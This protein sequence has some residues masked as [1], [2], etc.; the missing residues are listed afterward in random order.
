MGTNYYLL[1]DVCPHCNREASRKHIGKS[2]GG[3][4]FSLH[5]EP[6]DHEF[7]QSLE[8][9]I[10]LWSIPGNKIEDEY[11]QPVDPAEMLSIITERLWKNGPLMRHDYENLVRYGDGP[12]DLISGEFF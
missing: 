1:E 12:Y 3:W 9:W 5:V 2:S 8:Q 7:P 4:C 11:R 6:K 10:E